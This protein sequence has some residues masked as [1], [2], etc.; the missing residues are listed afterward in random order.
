MRDYLDVT[1]G[2]LAWAKDH[3]ADAAA[4]NG[5]EQMRSALLARID[6]GDS[7]PERIWLTAY[8][9]G[10]QEVSDTEATYRGSRYRWDHGP[11]VWVR[12][13]GTEGGGQ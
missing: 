10:F 6:G 1:A 8:P 9:E 5:L 3:G 2:I 11:C 7:A 4:V 12:I 13:D